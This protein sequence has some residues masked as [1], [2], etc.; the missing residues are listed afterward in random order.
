M[1]IT[2]VLSQTFLDEAR[3]LLAEVEEA[4]LELEDN[5]D[6]QEC[7]ARC[8]RAMHT[9]KGSAA[10][11]GFESVS[12][13]THDLET[14]LDLVRSGKLPPSKE[15]LSLTFQAKDQIGLLLDQGKSAFI[16]PEAEELIVQFKALLASPKAT[17]DD[18][19]PSPGPPVT[20]QA[21]G[22]PA[23][24]WVRYKPSEETLLSGNRPLGLM[25]E[26]AELG[27]ARF[28]FRDGDIPPLEDLTPEET[29]CWWDVL[30]HT[31]KGKSAIEDVFIFVTDEDLVS[32]QL[33]SE[34]GVR[35]T[36][37]DEMV[38]RLAALPHD[39]LVAI[40]DS[41][42]AYLTEVF[43]HREQARRMAKPEKTAPVPKSASIRVDSSR[44]DKLVNMV[45]EMVIIQSRLSQA[46]RSD[47]DQ[48]FM[49]RLSEDMERLTDELR[50]NALSL[51]MLPIGAVYNS[52]RR[53]TRDLSCALGKQVDFVT[54]GGETE[55]DKT[56]IDELKDPLVHILRN[57]VDHGVELPADR[58][59][60]GKPET[61]TVTLAARHASGQVVISVS[62]DGKGLHPDKIRK[63]AIEKGLIP[64]DAELQ[65]KEL[66][67]LIFKPGF[68]T[69]EK[70]TDVSGRG[71]GMDVVKQSI[72]KLRGHVDF[73]SSP[74]KGSTLTITLPLTLAI[75]DGFNV[76]VGDE[77]YIVPL[78]NLVGFQERFPTPAARCVETI[79]RMGELIPCISLRRLLRVGGPQ[80]DY[81]RVVITEV[82]GSVFGIAIDQVIGRQS[83]VLKSLSDDFKRLKWM[84]GATINGDGSISIILDIP[85]LIRH[86]EESY[87]P[88]R[89]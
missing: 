16:S 40:A 78:T 39:D 60:A 13:F 8:F 19:P 69:A 66:Y 27:V 56:V 34:G 32:V 85:Q 51:R 68:S 58:A 6:D 38:D 84:S 24:F 61:G 41:L 71:V 46:V 57:A 5:P 87:G 64:P 83:A 3:E 53:L 35:A 76:L 65:G 45:G 28:L 2:E 7:V 55:L 18:A 72:E 4:L 37:V 74:G 29:H 86:A 15:M 89:V 52:F 20:A 50:E 49:A 26:L 11:F 77:S 82:D 10:M 79:D 25:Q 21:P 70:V 44:L 30:L 80:P 17:G 67:S 31:D 22:R 73:D 75:I 9:I 81:E 36:E 43:T 1:S 48:T 23:T 63:R 12:R 42:T 88:L 33:L 47:M 62:D 14:V 59:L 54:L